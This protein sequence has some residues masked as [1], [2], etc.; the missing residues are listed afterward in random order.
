MPRSALELA[1]QDPILRVAGLHSTSLADIQTFFSLSD[2]ELDRI[3]AA[4]R[5]VRER[6]AWQ[7]ALRIRNVA[8]PTLENRLVAAMLLLSVLLA[9]LIVIVR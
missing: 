4:S 3:N 9:A 2:Q 6:P 8:D 1:Y 7:I 5:T